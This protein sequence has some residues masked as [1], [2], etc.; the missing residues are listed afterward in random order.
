MSSV[1]YVSYSWSVFTLTLENRVC[2]SCKYMYF[3]DLLITKYILHRYVSKN[4]TFGTSHTDVMRIKEYTMS[5]H[6]RVK[7][8]GRLVSV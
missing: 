2:V 4:W 7:M 8:F 1:F 5:S 6:M 3:D